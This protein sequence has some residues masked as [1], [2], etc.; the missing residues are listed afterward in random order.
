[1]G[2]FGEVGRDGERAETTYW[3]LVP[4]EAGRTWKTV[5]QR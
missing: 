5:E 4:D 1:V 3:R 2:A